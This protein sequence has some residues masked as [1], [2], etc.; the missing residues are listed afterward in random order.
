M[1]LRSNY[2][3][4]PLLIN[5]P[6]TWDGSQFA[7]ESDYIYQ[8]SA[9]EIQEVKDALYHFKCMIQNDYGVGSC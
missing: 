5:L 7:N 4:F 3:D 8:L 9:L 2:R 1:D 6:G